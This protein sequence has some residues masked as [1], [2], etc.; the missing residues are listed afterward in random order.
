M[1]VVVSGG[2]V[3]TP[4]DSSAVNTSGLADYNIYIGVPGTS[5]YLTYSATG[6]Y[7]AYLAMENV[8]P[9]SILLSAE[10]SYTKTVTTA[11]GSY[12]T[13]N[14]AYGTI[15]NML[16]YTTSTSEEWNVFMYVE[17]SS[18]WIKG[19]V[20]ALGFYQG[21]SDTDSSLRTANVFLYYGATTDT[22]SDVSDS[23]ALPTSGLASL[24]QIDTSNT[25][26]R[27]TITLKNSVSSQPS[28]MSDSLWTTLTALDGTQII[29]Y[30]S[31]CFTALQQGLSSVVGND[32]LYD[33]TDLVINNDSYGYV[34]EI[35]GIE[36]YS[37]KITDTYTM[38]W[39]WSLHDTSSPTSSNYLS[40]CAGFLT[41]LAGHSGFTYNSISYQY[42]VS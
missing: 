22:I 25:N 12:T 41:P 5:N 36:E 3:F 39:Y 34:S 28:W 37:L 32:E 14:D 20:N 1:F 15:Y 38:W 18:A 8:V 35:A 27:V 4:D 16:G 21:Y 6:Y 31:N 7:D 40:Y 19:P 2:V 11:W 9:S 23:Y 13:I 10:S 30:G 33:T 24:T 17:S 29:G 26:Y 42:E